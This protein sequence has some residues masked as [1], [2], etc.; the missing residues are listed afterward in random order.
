MLIFV[1]IHSDILK[2]DISS[3]SVIAVT[4]SCQC[5]KV[6]TGILNLCRSFAVETIV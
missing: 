4:S 1:K 5:V 3:F 2:V 6:I